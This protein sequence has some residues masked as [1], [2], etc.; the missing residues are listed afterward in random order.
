M[1]VFALCAG[2]ASG[3][4]LGAGLM[5]ELCALQPEARFVGIGGPAM[6]AEG[7]ESWFDASE[8]SVMGL[9]EVLRHLPRLLKLRKAFLEKLS[10]AAPAVYIGIDAPDFNLGVEQR[11]RRRGIR[12]IHYVSPS[13][14][15]WRQKRAA[16]IGR[17]ADLVLCLFPFEPSLYARYGVDARFVGH[18]F[19][20]EI[21]LEGDSVAARAKLGLNDTEEMLALLP[22]SRSGE[23]ERLGSDMLAAGRLLQ[24]RRPGLRLLLPAASAAARERLASQLAALNETPGTPARIEFIDG[25]AREVLMACDVALVASGTATLEAALCKR[26]MV[27]AYRIAKLTHWIVRTF[28]LLK[29][30]HY[31]LPNVL[32]Q[33]AIVP[34]IS[35]N[36]VTPERLAKEIERWFE[37][38]K[39]VAQLKAKFL[40]MHQSLRQNANARAAQVI[41]ESLQ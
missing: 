5:R 40:T 33:R 35:Q 13:I 14:W 26:P 7:L 23:I 21:A 38:P 16:K 36:D 32:A 28:K 19:A 39:G 6:R 15:A 9:V 24:Q 10:A 30:S 2:E 41:L 8:L 20:D 4:L 3:D 27:V 17:C 22:G 1:T 34:E 11:L 25:R 31:S 37:D 18:P 12:T 29:V